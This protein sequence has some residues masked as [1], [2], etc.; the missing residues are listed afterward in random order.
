VILKKTK[1]P[2]HENGMSVVE[3]RRLALIA[4]WIGLIAT[5]GVVFVFIPNIE[6]VIL[7]AFLGG[8]IMGPQKGFI[9]AA[10][11][12]AIF[13]ALNP[14]GSGLGFPILY[15]FQIFSVGLSGMIGGLFANRINSIPNSLLRSILM[16]LIGFLLTLFYDILTTLSFPLSTGLTEGT[17]W[18]SMTTGLVYFIMHMVSNTI[19]FVLFAPGLI[20][21]VNRQLLM[22]GLN[23]DL[24]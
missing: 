3:Y 24:A 19:L 11:G 2:D 22:H 10:I 1:A 13:S 17:L 6:L 14:I 5:V 18:G 8:V 9:A 23:R 15:V 16:G 4:L 20:D 7:V 12:E 21:L